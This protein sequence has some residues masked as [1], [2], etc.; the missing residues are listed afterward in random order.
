MDDERIDLSALDPGAA[1]DRVERGVQAVLARVAP[2]LAARRARGPVVWDVLRAW[3]RPVL[4][5]AALVA[6]LCA[7]VLGRVPASASSAG[8]TR[9]STLTEAAGVPASLAR[10]IESGSAPGAEFLFDL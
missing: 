7:A 6:L 9:A 1:P 4:A 3:R 8:D 10:S 2:S 5:A